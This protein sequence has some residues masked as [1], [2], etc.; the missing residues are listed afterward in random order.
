MLAEIDGALIVGLLI[1]APLILWIIGWIYAIIRGTARTAHYYATRKPETKRRIEERTE[2]GLR[3]RGYLDDV[4]ADR[5]A[6]GLS[7]LR[8]PDETERE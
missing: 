8:P 6:R 5:R 3:E 7:P 4:E 2:R 1:F